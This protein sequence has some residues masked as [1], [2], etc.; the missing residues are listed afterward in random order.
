MLT[1]EFPPYGRGGLGKACHGLVSGL[2]E[3]GVQVHLLIPCEGASGVYVLNRPGDA[4]A[5]SEHF[6]PFDFSERDFSLSS[7]AGIRQKKGGEYYKGDYARDYYASGA[8]LLNR[9][10]F[11]FSALT[12]CISIREFDLIHAHDWPTFP[13]AL[14]LRGMTGKPLVCHIHSTEFDRAPG[15]EDEKV[16]T[17]EMAGLS[18]CERAIAVSTYTASVIRDRY[19]IDPSKIRVVYNACG[20]DNTAKRKARI[21][22][23]PV[24]L[25]LGR[26][27]KQKGPETFLK[28]AKRAVERLT[29]IRFLMAGSGDLFCRIVHQSASMGLGTRFL[30]L[31]HLQTEELHRV[32]SAA[33]ILLAPSVSEPFGLSVLEAMSFGVVPI[34]SARAGVSEIVEHAEKVDPGDIDGMVSAVVGLAEDHG[35]RRAMARAGAQEASALSWNAAAEAVMDIYGELGC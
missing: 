7:P 17:V 19:G 31:G 30:P 22:K 12:A 20:K 28:V 16:Y 23:D 21:F 35:K 3:I 6:E 11:G 24:V 2:L 14:Q 33:D 25:F 15:T 34:V 1:W 27:T 29:A 5:L 26:V 18:V 13:A 9:G 10:S 32:L 4:D 8:D